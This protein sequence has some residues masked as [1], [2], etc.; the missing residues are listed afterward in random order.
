MSDEH[1]QSL[2]IDAYEYAFPLVIM[3]V[4][5]A[6]ATNVPDVATVPGRAPV[7]RFA[8]FRAYPSA[9]ARDVVRINFDTLYSVA[10]L[11]L[12]DEPLVLTVPNAPDRYHL[13]PLLDMWSDVFAV[14]GTRTTAGVGRDYLVVGPAWSGEVPSGLSV[15][16]SP[17]PVA[18]VIGRTQTNGPA[19]YPAVHA[20]QDQYGLV[21]L[22]GWQQ[23]GRAP[24]PTLPIDP[25]VDA[26][27]PPQ[28]QV[29][30]MDGQ[31]F[32]GR[33][34]ELLGEHPP[35]YNDYP[36]LARIERLGL[37][38][39]A[40]FAPSD[41]VAA[42]LDDG[43][44]AAKVD[45]VSAITDGTIGIESNHWQWMQ[46]GAG[47][48]GTDYRQRAMVAFAGLGCNLC[49]DALYPNAAVDG[50][51]FPLTGKH[52]YALRFAAG[53]LPPADAF[54]SLT[55]YDANGFQVANPI[56]RFAI[57]DRD[58][59]RFDDDGSL[60]LVI[61]RDSPGGDREANW[62]P[63][64]DGPFQLTMRIYSPSSDALRHGIRI[65][66]IERVDVGPEGDGH[67][68]PAVARAATGRVR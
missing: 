37:R 40:P 29:W 4:T 14:P 27:T 48:Y 36:I 57:G 47:S 42:V 52:R 58:P 8:H 10:W 33:F 22:S 20:V 59:L 12:R 17:T 18:W 46:Q 56:D 31:S 54:W 53:Q 55:M 28:K 3:D 19:D 60:E 1:L 41:E 34:A 63:A 30:S 26:V 11:D 67:R 62:L 68:R 25:E 66:A 16:R 6:Q 49:D 38:L 5:R 50:D 23:A 35:H 65:P 44:D 51:G 45:I 64:P 61:C 13:T 2:I 24:L 21:P 9:D 39:G 32:F 15:L 7:N 43:V